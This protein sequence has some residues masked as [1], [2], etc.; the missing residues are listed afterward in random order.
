MSS[1]PSLSDLPAATRLHAQGA[2]SIAYF[3][4]Q[5]IITLILQID[6][7][8]KKQFDFRHRR[9]TSFQLKN[10]IFKKIIIQW[11]QQQQ[12]RIL[13]E[14]RVFHRMNHPYFSDQLC[15]H[16]RYPFGLIIMANHLIWIRYTIIIVIWNIYQR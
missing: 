7:Y 6:R 3:D 10:L 12:H 15:F 13:K 1:D 11:Q 2:F 8:V 9:V 16:R 4:L 14:E 5:F